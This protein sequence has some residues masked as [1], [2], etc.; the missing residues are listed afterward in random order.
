MFRPSGAYAH[1]CPQRSPIEDYLC[2]LSDEVSDLPSMFSSVNENFASAATEG[3]LAMAEDS[4]DLDAMQNAAGEGGADVLPTGPAVQR[5]A[6]AI[7]KKWWHS[8]GYDCVI[9]YSC[10]TRRGICLFITF[11]SIWWFLL[12]YC[13]S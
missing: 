5:A 3:A 10:Q 12:Y 1:R 2:W 8:F 6:R 4:I 7:S 13:S 11:T 9:H